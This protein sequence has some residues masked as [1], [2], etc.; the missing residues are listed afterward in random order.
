MRKWLLLG[1]LLV[2]ACDDEFAAPSL[3]TNLRLLAVQ[4]DS[5]FAQPGQ[6]VHL[7]ALAHDPEQRPLSWAWGSCFDDASSLALDC[8]RATSF[9]SLVIGERASHSI[10]VPA[11]AKSYVGVVVVV[12]PGRIQRGETFG[13]PLSCVD[14]AGRALPPGDFELG[15]KRVFV[16]DPNQ[17]RNPRIGQLRWDG[18]P[19]PEGE[20]K[21]SA[22]KKTQELR[23]VSFVEHTIE[24]QSDAAEEM[25]VD[26][27]G[28]PFDEQA[29]VQLYATGGKF[30]HD[31]RAVKDAQTSWSARA[32]DSGELVTLWL[33][34]RDDRGGVSW[35]TRSIRVP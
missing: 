26:R 21:V 19:W 5:P 16:H 18:A 15:V 30:E 27:E 29:V 3:V 28:N 14:E 32:S 24:L 8:L 34:V 13:I 10:I 4:A 22:C 17:N 33:V 2:T 7:T 25:S 11:T 31:I 6:E 35:I 20:V 12:C 23:C 1:L 9:D